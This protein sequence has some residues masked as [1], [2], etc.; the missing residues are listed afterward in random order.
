MD[1]RH[2]EQIV[3]VARY[4]GFSDAARRLRISQPTLSK[5]IARLEA[6]MS[7]ELFHRDGGRARPTSYGR[8]LA[9][10]G[11]ALLKD[12]DALTRDFDRL[13]H[14]ER[15]QLRIGVGPAPRIAL[16]PGLIAGMMRRFPGLS[17]QTTQDNAM[18]VVRDLVAGSYD[19][20]FVHYAAAE[21]YD[22]L[23]RIKVMECPYLLV[24]RPGHP[25]LSARPLGPREL[26]KHRIASTL[27]VPDFA[28]WTGPLSGDE[29][30]NL[31][32][33]SS[34]SFD[35]LR[36]QAL[37]ADFIAIAPSFIFEADVR[38]GVLEAV[39]TTWDDVYECW[40]LTTRERWGSPELR[41][42]AD[43]ARQFGAGSAGD[44]DV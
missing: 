34:D 37:N 15:G 9:A 42:M 10:R 6:Q 19:V 1:L 40:M 39:A 16:L 18:R 2:L 29:A 31:K 4:G 44:D 8:F 17:I 30:Q 21:R 25:A 43:L 11:E 20:A 23:I 3:A 12:F 38:C 33:F 27:M 14:G 5:S 41:A 13:V 28:K 26:L 35:L 32:S 7:V 24:A 36:A 22:D